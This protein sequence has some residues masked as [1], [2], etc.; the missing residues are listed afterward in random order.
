M[1][2]FFRDHATRAATEAL[3]NI[4]LSA[5]F[6]ECRQRLIEAYPFGE[7]SRHPYKVWC[8]VQRELLLIRFSGRRAE[9]P[10]WL[11]HP[12]ADGPL[13]PPGA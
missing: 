9:L 13:F 2:S 3:K 4:P 8:Q 6:H 12:G 11:I 1:K 5:S 10:A 7:R